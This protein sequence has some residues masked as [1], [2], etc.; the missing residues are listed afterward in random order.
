MV[1][2][3]LVMLGDENIYKKKAKKPAK[4]DQ[5]IADQ[6]SFRVEE[7]FVGIPRP[8]HLKKKRQAK[9]AGHHDAQIRVFRRAQKWKNVVLEYGHES[10]VAAT[11]R[12]L[13][14]TAPMTPK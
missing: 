2:L 9:C 4:G 1:I 10:Q 3:D 12:I 7:L 11:F 5:G 13:H 8:D 6:R 14:Q